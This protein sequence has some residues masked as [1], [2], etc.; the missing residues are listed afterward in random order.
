[1]LP[2]THYQSSRDETGNACRHRGVPFDLP[3]DV[4]SVTRQWDIHRVA[5]FCQMHTHSKTCFKYCKPGEPQVCRFDLDP[6]NVIKCSSYNEETGDLCLRCLDGMVN[7]F[8]ATILE[9]MRCNMDIKFI[10]SGEGAKAITYY[11]TNYI[12][13]A[14]LKTHVAYAAFELAIRRLG[15]YDA[16]N[17]EIDPSRA[18][19]DSYMIYAK[20][21]LR[22]CAYSILANQELSAQQVAS[23]LLGD[24]DQYVSDTF[25]NLYWTSAERYMEKLLPSPECYVSTSP[26]TNSVDSSEDEQI[27][28][29]SE[30]QPDDDESDSESDS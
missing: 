21:M 7:N 14:Q 2:K 11:I 28:N 8:N 23:Y 9:A 22:R 6:A 13:K 29:N 15:E 18:Y 10:G 30:Q 17:I 19:E 20:R 26:Y 25:A 24:G 27:N 3:A 12:T 5:T 4:L 16:T 1:M